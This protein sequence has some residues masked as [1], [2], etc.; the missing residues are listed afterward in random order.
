M[1]TTA[2]P[3]A[4]AASTAVDGLRLDERVAARYA[5]LPPQERKGADV[6]LEHFG[7]LATYSAAEL[8]ALAGV[9][10][11]TMSRLF[12]SLGF[13]DFSQV[14]DHLRALRQHGLP[15]GLG[16]APDLDAHVEAEAAAVRV[17]V[18]ALAVHLD[19]VADLL[20]HAPRVVVVGLRTSYPLALHL[21]QQ[22]AQVRPHVALV[23]QPGQSLAEDLVDL[24]PQDAVVLVA[25]RRRP[26]GVRALVA[27]LA[28]AGTPVVLL[29]DPT[30]RALA[31][32]ATWWVQCPVQTRGAFDSY[33]AASSVVAALA[34][35]VL[36]RRGRT[37][38]QR[39]AGID[40]AYRALGEVEARGGAAER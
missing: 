35:A 9:S 10:K 33:A 28:E 13:D 7:D 8:A 26:P 1:T 30:A 11:A 16:D 29:A 25:L 20:A 21:R 34:D 38:E 32:H 4:S 12:R 39:V 6:L 15:L 5:E 14:R 36:G 3:P 22:L 40:S 27:R 31:A 18:A 19:P 2:P 24:S 17:A 37:G 23:P